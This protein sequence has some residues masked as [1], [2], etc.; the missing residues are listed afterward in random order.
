MYYQQDT[1]M[2]V[3]DIHTDIIGGVIVSVIKTQI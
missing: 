1:D 2:T 3:I